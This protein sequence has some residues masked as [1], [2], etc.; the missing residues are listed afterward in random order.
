[1][2][3][4]RDG[5]GL[6]RPEIARAAAALGDGPLTDDALRTHIDPLFS[7]ALARPG[8]YLANH[9]LGRPLDATADD[10]R[11]AVDLWYTD[12]DGAWEGWLAGM[13]RFRALW[14]A[15][16]G[17]WDRP[18]CVVPK[19][20]AGQGLRAVLSALPMD[21]PRVV[22]TEGEFDSMDFILR[23]WSERR[24]IELTLVP[25]DDRGVF[26]ARDI[27]RALEQPADLLLISHAFYATG[28]LLE[29]AGELIDRAHDR[30]ALVLL[31]TYHSAGVLP[32]DLRSLGA[33]GPDFAVG[34]SYK[35]A[36]GGP[37]ACWL[38]VRPDHA[39]GSDLRTLD[40]GW[41]AK[42]DTFGFDRSGPPRRKPGGDGWLESTPPVLTVFQALAGLELLLAIG[43]DRLRAHNLDQQA[44]LVRALSDRGVPTRDVGP[45]GAFVLVPA[46]DAPA[47]SAALAERGV[48]TDARLGC[49]RLCPDVLTRRDELGRAADALRDLLD[50]PPRPAPAP[51]DAR[52]HS[53]R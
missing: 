33:G 46:P 43:V 7:R 39:D 1:M 12:M 53:P 14:A 29:G 18:G 6:V 3:R 10:L 19:T 44:D 23:S 50:A 28:Q 8:V 49:V 47:A 48:F 24:R 2:N 36:R 32:M 30:G 15:L 52:A 38:A 11:A 35:Y 31:D 26:H 20:S 27:A 45:S 17:A 4:D 9:S 22:A 51:A 34:G 40:T 37:G 21:R 13:D 5:A 41:F 16:L 25:P 42:R